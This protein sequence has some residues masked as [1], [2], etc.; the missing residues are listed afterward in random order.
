[1]PFPTGKETNAYKKN[2]MFVTFTFKP[3][4]CPY[5]CIWH[6][7]TCLAINVPTRTLAQALHLLSLARVKIWSNL[8]YQ[9]KLQVSEGFEEQHIHVL[10]H[11]ITMETIVIEVRYSEV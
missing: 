6:V 2:A 10:M 4:T 1:M 9:T 5:A 3:C 7:L 11:C 8:V